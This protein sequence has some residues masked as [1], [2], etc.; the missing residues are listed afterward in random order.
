MKLHKLSD[1]GWTKE[2]D[3]MEDAKAELYKHICNYC[4]KG[5]IVKEEGR[6]DWLL[7]EPVDENSD[8]DML[9][10]TGCGCEFDVDDGPIYTMLEL[11]DWTE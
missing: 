8:I 4:R 1:P 6:E 7:W 5:E 11:K 10:N 3:S 9:L 2:F